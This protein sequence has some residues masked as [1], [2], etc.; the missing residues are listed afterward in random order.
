[1]A[2]GRS[3]GT[4]RRSHCCVLVL[5]LFRVEE[6]EG[7]L[8]H[9]LLSPG[10]TLL[11]LCATARTCR[12][13]SEGRGG[14]SGPTTG[15]RARTGVRR[16]RHAFDPPHVRGRRAK[17]DAQLF[18][19]IRGP[20]GMPKPGPTPRAPP[21][22]QRNPGGLGRARRRPA[23]RPFRRCTSPAEFCFVRGGPERAE[24]GPLR[25][26]PLQR[27]VAAAAVLQLPPAAASC[28]SIRL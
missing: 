27:P 15:L 22:P 16:E 19:R 18:P 2:I 8:L 9:L 11:D 26:S 4:P 13:A 20:D 25:G 24:G 7:S 10:H 23:P 21:P 1:M 17:K 5:V 12:R 6:E 28:P 3:S 14:R